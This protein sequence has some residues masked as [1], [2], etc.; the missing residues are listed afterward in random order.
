MEGDMVYL[1]WVLRNM[2]EWN[3]GGWLL[4]EFGR[5]E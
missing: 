1:K 2:G 4:K 3:L 5:V